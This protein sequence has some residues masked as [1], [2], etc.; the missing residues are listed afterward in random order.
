MYEA[1]TGLDLHSFSV[2]LHKLS[3]ISYHYQDLSYKNAAYFVVAYS[4]F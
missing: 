1:F 4:H 3:Y 2:S